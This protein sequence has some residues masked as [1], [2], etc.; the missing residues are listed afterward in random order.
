MGELKAEHEDVEL[1]MRSSSPP[2]LF[3]TKLG[4]AIQISWQLAQVVSAE[5]NGRPCIRSTPST[6]STKTR[7]GRAW[8]HDEHGALRRAQPQDETPPSPS[9]A[10]S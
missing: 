3:S 10:M 9:L 8:A 4:V 1:N 2:L 6:G 5:L 7:S